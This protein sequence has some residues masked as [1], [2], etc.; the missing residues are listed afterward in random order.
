MHIYILSKLG[1]DIPTN[2]LPPIQE[3]LLKP[4][5]YGKKDL[6]LIEKILK[7]NKNRVLVKWL[8]Y[9]VPTWEPRSILK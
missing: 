1:K 6:F 2:E 4:A 3:N 7:K 8:N 5:N 9:K